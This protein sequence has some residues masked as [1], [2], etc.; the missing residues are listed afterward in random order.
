MLPQVREGGFSTAL[1]ERYQRTEQALVLTLMEMVVTGVSTRKV[2]RITEELCGKEFSKST[3]SDLCQRVQEWNERAL[4][5]QAFPFV[6]VDAWGIKVREEGQVRAVS[7]LLATGVN[8]DGYREISNW[9]TASRRSVGA[10]CFAGSR[11]AGCT[12]SMS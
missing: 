7:A 8:A 9:G 1:F 6:V 2:A 10:A 3:V 5:E 11:S 4:G 12:A